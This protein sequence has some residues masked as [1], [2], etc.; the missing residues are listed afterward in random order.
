VC[1]EVIFELLRFV[2]GEVCCVNGHL[3]L[4][5]QHT[6][7]PPMVIAG[8]R[9]IGPEAKS[10]LKRG[11]DDEGLKAISDLLPEWI[12]QLNGRSGLRIEHLTHFGI[13][14]FAVQNLHE[15]QGTEHDDHAISGKD[16]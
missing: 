8:W 4:Y 11:Q 7:Y 14:T 15:E 1:L 3:L 12:L 6:K 13:D 9:V 2:P 16:L 5:C 10:R